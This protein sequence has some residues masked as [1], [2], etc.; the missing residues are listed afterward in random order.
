MPSL[1]PPGL[2]ALEDLPT[3]EQPDDETLS[4]GSSALVASFTGEA[5]GSTTSEES[6][7]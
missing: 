7:Y 5:S 2:V 4:A 6:D 3:R 1:G